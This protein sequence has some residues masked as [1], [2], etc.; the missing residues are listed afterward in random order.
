MDEWVAWQEEH[1]GATHPPSL[2]SSGT[3][4]AAAVSLLLGSAICSL[5]CDAVRRCWA[6]RRGLVAPLL[7]RSLCALCRRVMR[8]VL[9]NEEGIGGCD[10]IETKRF[11]SIER[12]HAFCK[13]INLGPGRPSIG[14][15]TSLLLL[16]LPAD[17]LPKSSACELFV[18][19]NAEDKVQS[20]RIHRP[21]F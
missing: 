16:L 13:P 9:F 11:V 20:A 8:W 4:A 7:L 6:L 14:F 1:M 12:M 15:D 18:F 10:S 2:A 5:R 3:V 19:V 17:S 21:A